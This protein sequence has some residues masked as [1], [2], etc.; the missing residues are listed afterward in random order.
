MKMS[1][2]LEFNNQKVSEAKVKTVCDHLNNGLRMLSICDCHISDKTFRT[3]LKGIG[4]CKALLQ[5]TLSV[6]ILKD[7]KRVE[8]LGDALKTNRSLLSLS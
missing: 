5:L 1:S 3:L 8:I 2:A 6:N 7:A 4:N